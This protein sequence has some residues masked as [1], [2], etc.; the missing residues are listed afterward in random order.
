MRLLACR[1]MVLIMYS[2]WWIWSTVKRRTRDIYQYLIQFIYT[3]SELTKQTTTLDDDD[4]D[5]ESRMKNTHTHKLALIYMRIMYYI[6]N[7]V[8]V[9][10]CISAHCQH[11][12]SR[13]KCERD[14]VICA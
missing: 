1:L 4:D 11:E 6:H 9:A 2:R 10:F 12:S 3:P 8:Y 14:N 13:C 7:C 5:D